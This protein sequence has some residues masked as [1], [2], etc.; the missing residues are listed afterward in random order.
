LGNHSKYILIGLLHLVDWD[1]PVAEFPLD[2]KVSLCKYKGSRVEE[3]VNRL[4]QTRYLDEG[5]PLRYET[6]IVY[7]SEFNPED[8]YYLRRVI[9]LICSLIGIVYL[10]A[11]DL[12]NVIGTNDYK[13]G[14]IIYSQ[15]SITYHN[16]FLYNLAEDKGV[17]VIIN[18]ETAQMVKSFWNNLQ[19]DIPIEFDRIKNAL[20]FYTQAWK[21]GTD[22]EAV[23]NLA[24]V[25]ETLFAPHYQNEL[26]HQIAMNI[27]RFLRKSAQERRETYELVK[28]IYA[29][30][31]KIVHGDYPSDSTNFSK[32]LQEAYSLCA[33]LLRFIL[34]D[35]KLTAI[36]RDNDIRR[37]Y[38]D[39]L[40]FA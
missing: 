30:R 10:G 21:S 4:A 1:L 29:V 8:Y 22:E 34:I 11:P 9:D 38:L 14:C 12:V 35:K 27:C 13:D 15:G 19:M 24:I 37:E 6:V 16:E 3:L 23:I 40:Q 26:S 20:R 39:N 36:F 17:K 31:S 28:H 7:D 18:Q 32:Y 2:S 25:L 5:E 33:E